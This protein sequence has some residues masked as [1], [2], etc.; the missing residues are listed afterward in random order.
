MGEPGVLWGGGTARRSKPGSMRRTLC[1]SC[2]ERV[3]VLLLLE[4]DRAGEEGRELT[5]GSSR[6]SY[7]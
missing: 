3:A 4:Q 5:K 7:H 1:E 2:G 6:R